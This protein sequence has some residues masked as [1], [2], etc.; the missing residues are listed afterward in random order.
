MVLPTLPPAQEYLLPPP[1]RENNFFIYIT[2]YACTK[3]DIFT[4]AWSKTAYLL[5]KCTYYEFS[6]NFWCALIIFLSS[7]YSE[8]FIILSQFVLMLA[9]LLISV[10]Y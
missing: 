3:F 9:F 10:I 1:T 7:V 4:S 5:I 6:L 2:T 8:Y